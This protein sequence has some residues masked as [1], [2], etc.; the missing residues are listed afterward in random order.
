MG[1]LI[2]SPVPT[3]V[4]HSFVQCLLLAS[5]HLSREMTNCEP[6][7][8]S[9]MAYRIHNLVIQSKPTLRIEL[10]VDLFNR[11]Q[12]NQQL[13]LI[14]PPVGGLETPL[15]LVLCQ[16]HQIPCQPLPLQA[17]IHSHSAQL[18]RFCPISHEPKAL[19]R[20]RYVPRRQLR[21]F[22]D[23]HG[24]QVAFAARSRHHV[25]G[26]RVGDHIGECARYIPKFVEELSIAPKPLLGDLLTPFFC[27]MPRKASLMTTMSDGSRGDRASC[28]GVKSVTVVG[29]PLTCGPSKDVG[30][31][32]SSSGLLATF[33]GNV[34]PGSMPLG[35]HG[36]L[37]GGVPTVD[38][39]GFRSRHNVENLWIL[40]KHSTG[41][42]LLK[43][44]EN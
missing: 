32:E 11:R 5:L 1:P 35:V 22:H 7:L 34:V 40:D 42:S 12:Q 16:L 20:V 27:S 19:E 21:R 3:T 31:L 4:F 9:E 39:W 33:S 25:I 14:M 28:V 23:I 37:E 26:T 18:P 29:A 24:A 17:R 6:G 38:V 13:H 43:E 2:L 8:S 10:L 44:I 15:D 36:R 30:A 41:Q